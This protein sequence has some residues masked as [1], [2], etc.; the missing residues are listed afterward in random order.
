MNGFYCFK[1]R[2]NRVKRCPRRHI[3]FNC[4]FSGSMVLLPLLWEP[5]FQCGQ[6]MLK[7]LLFFSWESGLIC[8]VSFS[9]SPNQCTQQHNE[10]PPHSFKLVLITLNKLLF[11]FVLNLINK[12]RLHSVH[13]QSKLHFNWGKSV[14]SLLCVTQFV[15]V[16]VPDNFGVHFWHL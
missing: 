5:I 14:S 13:F 6:T 4:G 10:N 11:N 15:I 2:T 16:F 12:C 7:L 3:C 9:P 1:N 8:P